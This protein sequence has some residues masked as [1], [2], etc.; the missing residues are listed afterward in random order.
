MCTGLAYSYVTIVY[1]SINISSRS[2]VCKTSFCS[3]DTGLAHVAV[4]KGQGG[5]GEKG[6]EKDPGMRERREMCLG[7]PRD[8]PI[9]V[10]I[11]KI[12]YLFC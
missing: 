5:K 3:T 6:F 12:R 11:H 8:N 4:V 7:V 2:G 10:E 1:N 9:R